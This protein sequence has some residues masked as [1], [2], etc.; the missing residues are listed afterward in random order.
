MSRLGSPYPLE[1]A[2]DIILNSFPKCYDT[3]I[4]NYNI[5][6]WD[7]PM[8]ELHRM[9][10]TE[11]KNIPRE[12]PQVLTIREGQVKKKKQGKNFKGNFHNNTAA[13]PLLYD[14]DVWPKGM[15]AAAEGR[16][17]FGSDYP[18][19]LYPRTEVAP[20]LGGILGEIKSAGL[21]EQETI[22]LLGGNAAQLL[23]E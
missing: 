10:K 9:L 16:V 13:S 6:G 12:T 7:K 1:F 11:K 19:I 21:T 23:A 18:L 15:R 5:N 22:A 14:A 20:E 17:I 4:M 2:T 3:F 8:S